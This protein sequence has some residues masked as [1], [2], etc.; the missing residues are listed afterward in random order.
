MGDVVNLNHYRKRRDRQRAARRAAENR[1]KLGRGKLERE[2]THRDGE[3]HRHK[4]DGK[5]LDRGPGEDTPA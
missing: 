2:S 3:R 4:L 1:A 5:R